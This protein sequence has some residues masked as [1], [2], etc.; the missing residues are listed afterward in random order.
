M[1]KTSP[2]NIEI[3]ENPVEYIV[4]DDTGTYF[5]F[6]KEDLQDCLLTHQHA[7]VFKTKELKYAITVTVG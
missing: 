6:S 2:I 5:C 3:K 7:R 1:K 4:I